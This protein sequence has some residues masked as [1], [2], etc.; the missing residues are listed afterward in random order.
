MIRVYLYPDGTATAKRIPTHV[1]DADLACNSADAVIDVDEYSG[2]ARVI[3][4]RFTRTLDA[5]SETHRVNDDE[6]H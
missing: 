6:A 1:R 3:K 2:E 5:K 4:H